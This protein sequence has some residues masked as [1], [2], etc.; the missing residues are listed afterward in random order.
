LTLSSPN[1]I[2]VLNQKGGVGETTIAVNFAA[3]FAKCITLFL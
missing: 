3:V 1:R 2:G